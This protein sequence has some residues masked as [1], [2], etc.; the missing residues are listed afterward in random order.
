MLK[1]EIDIP[2]KVK[3]KYVNNFCGGDAGMKKLC[4]FCKHWYMESGSYAYSEWT[5]GWDYEEYCQKGNWKLDTYNTCRETTGKKYSWQKR[6]KGMN[7]LR[8]LEI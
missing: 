3:V 2:N 8:R 5:P 6:V 7:M 1:N 4:V